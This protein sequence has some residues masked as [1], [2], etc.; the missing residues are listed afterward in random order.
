MYKMEQ[1][2]ESS[3]PSRLP[4]DGRESDRVEV[5]SAQNLRQHVAESDS[6]TE[7][8]Y[9]HFARLLPQ[10][11][12]KV[13]DVGC[14]TGRGG[15]VLSELDVGLIV[16]GLDC[17][18]SRLDALPAC[19]RRRLLGLASDIPVADRSYD[20][21]VAGEFLEHLYPIDV[22]PTLCELQRV[23]K[24]GGRLLLTTPNPGYLLNRVLG[25]SV[26]G[27]AHLT[28]HHPQVLR[29]RLMQ[30]GFSKVRLSGTGKVSRYVGTRIPFL[31]L[32]GSYMLRADKF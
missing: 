21:I 18:Q 3:E 10:G 19:Y 26:Y 12:V 27:T 24:I 8:R 32:Y 23:L 15:R 6:F 5:Y 25:R 30:H 2:D 1:L 28:Q 11:A 16:D 13:L 29:N 31:P 9:L 22:D 7:T 20:A 17:A 4:D 14:A